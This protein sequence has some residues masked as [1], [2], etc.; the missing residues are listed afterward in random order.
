MKHIF[1]LKLFFCATILFFVTPTK[2]VTEAFL[3]GT[4]TDRVRLGRLARQADELSTV[5]LSN[6]SQLEVLDASVA[7]DFG[8]TWTA[9]AQL[10]STVT[11]IETKIDDISSDM[12]TGFDGTWTA[13]DDVMTGWPIK[14]SDSYSGSDPI[15]LSTAGR[16]QLSEDMTKRITVSGDYIDLDLNQHTISQTVSGNNNITI[17][18]SYC[19]VH[20]GRVTNSSATSGHGVL[21]SDNNNIVENITASS[22]GNGF[23]CSSGTTNN[24]IFSCQA[25]DSYS[26]GF[27]C[28]TEQ[29]SI[30]NCLVQTINETGFRLTG[31]ECA[32]ENCTAQGES[33]RSDL[34]E[35]AGFQIAAGSNNQI[36]NCLAINLENAGTGLLGIYGIA[37]KSEEANTEVV[38]C[39][40]QRIHATGSGGSGHT[41]PFTCGIYIEPTILDT[42]N[43]LAS[44]T[45]P[46][47]NVR[48]VYWSPDE[49]YVLAV[50]AANTLHVF[51]FTGSA[52]NHLASVTATGAYVAQWSPDGRF[53]AVADNS[54][55]DL[56]IYEFTG[57]SFEDKADSTEPTSVVDLDWSPNGKFIAT[58]GDGDIQV[59]P[60][61]PDEGY[62]GWP[63]STITEAGSTDLH[64]SPCGNYLAVGDQS[65][66]R[67]YSANQGYLT[68]LTTHSI[69]GAPTINNI[70]WSP[71]G[72]FIATVDTAGDVRIFYFSGSAVTDTGAIRDTGTNVYTVSWAPDGKYICV[73]FSNS[74]VLK[75]EFDRL[76]SGASLTFVINVT[77]GTSTRSVHWSP[78]GQ[79]IAH[80][81][82]TF[83]EIR[84]GMNT[85]T[86]C[87][88][89]G[90]TITD[91]S[92]NNGSKGIST[93]GSTGPAASFTRNI[94][95]S[96]DI[97]FPYGIPNSYYGSHDL[98][99]PFDNLAIPL[100]S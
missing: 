7:N 9:L 73:G 42:I 8:G 80:G 17:S 65:V 90:S 74:V 4:R 41:I 30:K 64:W 94:C 28:T 53:I 20:N 51:G 68:A 22:C 47:G 32:I 78:S 49:K 75:L 92:T 97:N 67:V 54:G 99:K 59:Y 3:D 77:P 60:V 58:V 25:I 18:G 98:T 27:T 26:H 88:V 44:D 15:T 40:I 85:C 69:S 57:G 31:T 48:Y 83:V 79:Y 29:L 71:C 2:A 38:N 35:V 86:K 6:E 82:D 76:T 34:T 14:I 23:G 37:L 91:I 5:H 93:G 66:I 89:D 43:S 87:K 61:D 52:L 10:D 16:Y 84:E 56:Q 1:S 36:K 95:C 39:G 62:I 45:T 12:A 21:I 63:I 19:R 70:K 96:N 55:G 100:F 46:S 11:T 33:S 50:D 13:I 24:R 72:A 81:T